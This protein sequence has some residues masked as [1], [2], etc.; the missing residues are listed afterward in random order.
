MIQKWIGKGI[1]I[2]DNPKTSKEPEPKQNASQQIA[3]SI[4]AA[5]TQTPK[6]IEQANWS[7]TPPNGIGSISYADLLVTVPTRE[8]KKPVMKL[9]NSFSPLVQEDMVGKIAGRPPDRRKNLHYEMANME[10]ERSK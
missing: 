10:C 6:N 2:Q 9:Q 3:S 7:V 1:K 5:D 8:H 4:T